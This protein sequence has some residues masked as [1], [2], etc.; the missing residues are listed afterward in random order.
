MKVLV[1][2]SGGFIGR[3]LTTKLLREG[4]EVIEHR[5]SDGNLADAESLE[6]Y[7]NINVVFHLASRTFVPD[8]WVNPEE[9]IS[10]NTSML[11]NV[12]KLC[13]KL[14]SKLVYMSSYMYGTPDYIPIDESHKC[15]SLTPYHLSKKIGE[16]ICKFYSD[17]YGVDVVVIRPF[18]VY[19]KGQNKEFLLPRVFYQVMDEKC[20]KIE[21]MDL[22]PRRDYIY[23]E[24]LVGI[25]V[26]L[27]PS[28]EGY[29]VYNIG[30]GVSYSVLEVI[31]TIQREFATDKRIVVKNNIRK[32]EVMD[33]VADISH[34][35]DKV[36]NV[37]LMS[38]EEGVH[39]WHL[40]E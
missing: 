35:R 12:L 9:Y 32:N 20:N 27:V 13:R 14:N 15:I 10:D 1:T 36:G 25:M 34:L 3:Y 22:E 2:G 4:Y 26:R 40:I 19:G 38:L 18:N 5:R 23:V 30:T 39:K 29:D 24:D 16:E 37:A 17:Y 31:N 8:S 21:V 28:I 7:N 33:C 6:Q 11:A